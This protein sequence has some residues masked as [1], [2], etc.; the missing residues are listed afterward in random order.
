MK[1]KHGKM[2]CM[3][4][5]GMNEICKRFEEQERRAKKIVFANETQP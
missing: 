4:I 2:E 3:G 5:F 1:E